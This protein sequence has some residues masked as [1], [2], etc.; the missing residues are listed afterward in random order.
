MADSECAY[1][2]LYR[3]GTYVEFYCIALLR[4]SA[5][6]R[7]HNKDG[8]PISHTVPSCAEVPYLLSL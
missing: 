6:T 8:V 3:D 1:A 5:V 2:C 7:Y 4:Y